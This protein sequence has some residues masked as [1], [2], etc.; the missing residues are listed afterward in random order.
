MCLGAGE[1][2][3]APVCREVAA[4]TGSHL[5]LWAA[6]CNLACHGGMC[7]MPLFNRQF[8]NLLGCLVFLFPFPARPGG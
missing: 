1:E 3:E 5:F 6:T 7:S 4:P 8:A 2:K